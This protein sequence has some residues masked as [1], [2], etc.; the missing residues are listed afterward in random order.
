MA[1]HVTQVRILVLSTAL[2]LSASA[3]AEAPETPSAPGSSYVV[4]VINRLPTLLNEVLEAANPFHKLYDEAVTQLPVY[5]NRERV[6]LMAEERENVEHAAQN[7][8]KILKEAPA[9]YAR[10]Y[11]TQNWLIHSL[12]LLANDDRYRGLDAASREKFTELMALC[13]ASLKVDPHYYW[14]HYKRGRG[15]VALGDYENA[16]DYFGQAVVEA[17]N[18][19]EVASA[20]EA[21]NEDVIFAAKD[22]MARA[23]LDRAEA[24]AMVGRFDTARVVLEQLLELKSEEHLFADAH[25]LLGQMRLLQGAVPAANAEFRE[26]VR[27]SVSLDHLPQ[28]LIFSFITADDAPTKEAIAIDMLRLVLNEPL[29]EFGLEWYG[30]VMTWLAWPHVEAVAAR[31]VGPGHETPEAVIAELRQISGVQDATPDSLWKFVENEER[32]RNDRHRQVSE[33]RTAA[34]YYLGSVTSGEAGQ[35]ACKQAAGANS[36]PT[37]WEGRQAHASVERISKPNQIVKPS[38]G[39]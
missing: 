9:G 5:D 10:R 2:L 23:T 15:A 12:V 37:T 22:I 1:D 24:L 27:L 39:N 4:R 14:V 20:A 8:R 25:A 30:S 11:Y 21:G 7:F 36:K 33:L 3:A 18:V 32:R 28:A 17:R 38:C 31:L 35:E 16:E 19:I 26:A 29:E 13:D 34:W 6:Y